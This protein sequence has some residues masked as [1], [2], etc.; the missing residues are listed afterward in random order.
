MLII[1]SGAATKKITHIVKKKIKM[2]TVG[3]I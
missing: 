3:D 1:I 2:V